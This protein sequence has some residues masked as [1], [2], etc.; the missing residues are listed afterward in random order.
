MP[1]V[2]CRLAAMF[3]AVGLLFASRTL[4]TPERAAAADPAAT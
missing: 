3:V 4:A 2:L 1:V